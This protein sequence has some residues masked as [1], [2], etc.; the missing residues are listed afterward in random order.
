MMT[1]LNLVEQFSICSIDELRDEK[2]RIVE[3]TY[4]VRVTVEQPE[5]A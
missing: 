1:E 4:H 5:E 2:S 3:T